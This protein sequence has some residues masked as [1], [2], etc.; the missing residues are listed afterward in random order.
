[1]EFSPHMG[2]DLVIY[3]LLFDLV[4]WMC[5]TFVLVA[6]VSFRTEMNIY[7]YQLIHRLGY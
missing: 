3:F 1:M 6:S 7:M 2:G 4:L 5:R